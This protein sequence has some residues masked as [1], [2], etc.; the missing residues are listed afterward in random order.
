MGATVTVKA[1]CQEFH[2]KTFPLKRYE[3]NLEGI[4]TQTPRPLLTSHLEKIVQEQ[5]KFFYSK[6]IGRFIPAGFYSGSRDLHGIPKPPQA[7]LSLEEVKTLLKNSTNTSFPNTQQ[8]R[9]VCEELEELGDAFFLARMKDK[10]SVETFRPTYKDIPD[11]NISIDYD[12]ETRD[13]AVHIKARLFS[14]FG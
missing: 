7:S 6:R 13:L 1:A 5:L 14:I 4:A 3:L 10:E 8:S 11:F 2:D 9:E 12:D